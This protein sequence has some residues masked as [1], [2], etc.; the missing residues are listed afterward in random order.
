[1]LLLRPCKDKKKYEVVG[2]YTYKDICV[3]SGYETDGVSYKFRLL[4]LFLDKFD[5]RFMEAVVIH[6]Y[7][8]D[9]GEWDKANRYFEE[10]LP[11]VE[12]K[13]SMV[14]AVNLY[15]RFIIKGFK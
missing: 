3:P 9:L 13:T 5:P 2:G 4:G 10:L 7:L 11:A 6:D 1:M 12:E 8:T 15:Y 14:K